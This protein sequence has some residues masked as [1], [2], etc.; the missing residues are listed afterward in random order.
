MQRPCIWMPNMKVLID[1]CY[2]SDLRCYW[3]LGCLNCSPILK[4]PQVH[5]PKPKW[6]LWSLKSA[7]FCFRNRRLIGGINVHILKDSI[8]YKLMITAGSLFQFCFWETALVKHV[9]VTWDSIFDFELCLKLQI[10]SPLRGDS[11][12][13]QGL[14]DRFRVCTT[15]QRFFSN[16]VLTHFPT[17]GFP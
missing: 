16:D 1:F 9:T 4:M 17:K 13:S 7:Y 3:S 11:I 15:T 14:T 10:P 2:T 6:T 8:A 5:Y 12:T